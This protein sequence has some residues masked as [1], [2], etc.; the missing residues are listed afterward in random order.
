MACLKV[1]VNTWGLENAKTD[2]QMGAIN[3]PRHPL[4]LPFYHHL[5]MT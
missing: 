3:L 2:Y 1:Y 4:S 5:L